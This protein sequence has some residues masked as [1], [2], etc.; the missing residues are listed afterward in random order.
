MIIALLYSRKLTLVSLDEEL[1]IS[2]GENVKKLRI[3]FFFLVTFLTGAAIALSGSIVFAGL[4]IPHFVRKIV[5]GDYR[6]IIPVSVVAGAIFLILA[7]MLS[8][9]INAPYETPVTAIMAVV[10]YP[11]FLYVVRRGG[12]AFD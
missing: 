9:I 6:H 10:S 8:R 12:G 7:D 1:A 3:L 4:I 11:I 2:L 5:G